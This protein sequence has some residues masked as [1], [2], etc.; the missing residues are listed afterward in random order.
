MLEE[1]HRV[2]PRRYARRGKWLIK[3]AAIWMVWHATLAPAQVPPPPGLSAPAKPT[4]MPPFDLPTT[5]G[6]ALRS[7][8]LRGQVV[9]I[10][11]WASW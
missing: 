5:A 2:S 4:S 3:I 7:E 11:F 8:A 6:P 1:I 9:V 10:R